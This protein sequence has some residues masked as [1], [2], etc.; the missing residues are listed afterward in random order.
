MKRVATGRQIA[1]VVH[2]ALPNEIACLPEVRLWL[3]VIEK[4]LI[5]ADSPKK[6]SV[7][8]FFSSDS[9]VLICNAIGLDPEW[10]RELICDH[11]A[12]MRPA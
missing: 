1:V 11:A 5:E 12:W 2:R 3:E 7:R 4:S 10:V 9:F 6:V 8:N